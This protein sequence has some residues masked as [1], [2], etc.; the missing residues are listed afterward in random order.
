METAKGKAR[1][2]AIT[3]LAERIDSF[4]KY[5]YPHSR[6]IA[7]LATHLARRFG[8]APSDVH[9][10]A[11]AAFLHDI[12]LQAM[13]PAYHGT[14]GQLSFEERMDLWRHTVIGEQQMAK[15]D[16]M[17]HAQLLVRWHHEWWNGTGYPD[18]LAFEDI[19][20]GA[21]ILRAVE[22]YSALIADRPYRAALNADQA[23]ETLKAAAGIECDPYVVKALV[24]LLDDMRAYIEQTEAQTAAPIDEAAPVTSRLAAP[25]DLS[26]AAPREASPAA[27]E[28]T[29]PSDATAP[30]DDRASAID[31]RS[32]V[33]SD[34]QA[35]GHTPDAAND[36]RAAALDLADQSSHA[37]PSDSAT[38]PPSANLAAPPAYN[39]HNPPPFEPAA[40]AP[41][42]PPAEITPS[43]AAS[44]AE[45]NAAPLAPSSPEP[46]V[47][48]AY[49]SASSRDVEAGYM[50]PTP[51]AV[52]VQT[53]NQTDPLA[54]RSPSEPVL[55]ARQDAPR[56]LDPL[57]PR[58]RGAEFVDQKVGQ[59]LAWGGS[60]YNRKALL[61]FEAS[62]LRQQ[63]FRSIAIPYYGWTRLDLYLKAWGK[64][65]LAND[66]RAWA[67]CLARATVEARV[68]LQEEQIMRVLEDVYVPGAKM[69]N[70]DLGNWFSEMDAWW[71][72]NLRRNI[73]A[74][75]D[76]TLRAQALV[77]GIMTGDYALSFDEA[78]RELKKPLTTV[79]WRLAGRTTMGPASSA[80]NRSAH[81]PVEEFLKRARADLLYL[82]LPA[83]HATSAGAEARGDWR[84]SW[85]GGSAQT[86]DPKAPAL[87]SK[88]AYLAMIDK[89]LQAAASFRTWAI[90]YQE[91]G[92]ASAAE[93]GE[94]IKA[95]RAVRA[96][97]SKDLTEVSGGLRSYIIIAQSQ[98][99]G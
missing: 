30:R 90:E 76:E 3:K 43:L 42:L 35:S 25:G 19:P 65:I 62:V 6:L 33:S 41:A 21:R 31:P 2:E 44:V 56:P 26:P 17:R 12:G 85:V 63:E 74:L 8:L 81:Q 80:Y 14:S 18:G 79:F 92:M 20:I 32:R 86:G 99:A 47:E 37:R 59:W 55:T 48:T 82:N 1:E 4:E 9:A 75:D 54:Y 89:L 87:Q 68:P 40:A 29:A 94:I 16:G 28:T 83:P 5:S 98:A 23:M 49:E 10:I 53:T 91:T 64:H 93:I 50:E 78:T 71:M 72:D 34:W 11:E 70:P 77:L 88:H 46:E 58:A 38:Q 66:P 7:E 39:P 15:R 95:H 69:V 52:P 97:Y 96:T 61:G 60:H 57:R 24:S 27:P 73:E 13:S 67:A 84:E 36:P 22:L 51:A 45:E